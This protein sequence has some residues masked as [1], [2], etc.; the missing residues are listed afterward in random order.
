MASCS[1][2]CAIYDRNYDEFRQLYNDIWPK[3]AHFCDMYDD[4]I[5]DGVFDGPKD[6]P[7]FADKEK[8]KK[9]GGP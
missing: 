3:D 6:C 5:P 7:Y 8:H 4:R 1:K 9:G 2:K